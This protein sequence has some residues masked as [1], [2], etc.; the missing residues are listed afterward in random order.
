MLADIALGYVVVGSFITVGAL[1]VPRGPLV[2]HLRALSNWG[3][4]WTVAVDVLGWPW[5][6]YYAAKELR[7]GRD[8]GADHTADPDDA[9]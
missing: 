8:E 6:V 1:T 4:F 3:V 7:G 2:E 9:S 5:V